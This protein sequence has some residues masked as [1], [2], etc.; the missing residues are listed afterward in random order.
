MF[1]G[2][3]FP[4]SGPVDS[5]HEHFELLN[6]AKT[7]TELQKMYIPRNISFLIKSHR[8]RRTCVGV[9]GSVSTSMAKK[10]NR[11]VVIDGN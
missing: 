3:C 11:G 8:K 9:P 4:P 2:K 10:K 5:H 1:Y 7:A 6:K